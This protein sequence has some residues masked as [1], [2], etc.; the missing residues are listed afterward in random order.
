MITGVAL[1]P[2]SPLIQ[3]MLDNKS[4]EKFEGNFF[5]TLYYKQVI[6]VANNG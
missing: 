2:D 5:S 1:L 6:P 4:E 3:G